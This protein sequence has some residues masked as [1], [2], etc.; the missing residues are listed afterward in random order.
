MGTVGRED[1]AKIPSWYGKSRRRTVRIKAAPGPEII[2]DLC[3]D[4]GPVD[5]I[6]RR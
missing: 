1:V 2:R 3:H 5:G 6:D 4:P